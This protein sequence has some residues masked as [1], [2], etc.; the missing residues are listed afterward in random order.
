[1][2]V[3]GIGGCDIAEALMIAAVIIMV[4]EDGDL[5]F[6]ITGQIV[7]FEQ[8]AVFQCLVPALDFPLGLRMTRRAAYMLDVL[9]RKPF[10]QITC[11]ITRPII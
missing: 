3:M 5:P 8:D 11:D 1:M 10:S 6:E 2:T 4:D 9:A 7:V